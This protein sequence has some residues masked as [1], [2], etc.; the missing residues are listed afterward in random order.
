MRIKEV[1]LAELAADEVLVRTVS[2]GICATDSTLRL[3]PIPL[4]DATV[5][6]HEASG[7]IEA[8]GPGV[9]SFTPGERVIVC[10]Q[11]FCGRCAAC[12]SGAM[13]YCTDTSGKERRRHRMTL[14]GR[15]GSTSACPRSPS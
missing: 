4:P 2:A 15:S 7:V 14:A 12:L 11:I 1:E 3:R 9:T 13:V 6:G 8:T 10:D 5:L